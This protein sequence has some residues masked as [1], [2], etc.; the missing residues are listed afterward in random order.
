[1]VV[2]VVVVA[3]HGPNG[4]YFDD[5]VPVIVV[6]TDFVYDISMMIPRMVHKFWHQRNDS[7]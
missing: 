1:M 7:K 4:V 6:I 3:T 2:V 5:A